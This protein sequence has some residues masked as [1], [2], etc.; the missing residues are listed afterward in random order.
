MTEFPAPPPEPLPEPLPALT[1]VSTWVP[2]VTGVVLKV[3]PTEVAALIGTLHVNDDDGLADFVVYRQPSPLEGPR[4]ADV[5]VVSD[6]S[7]LG[8]DQP[9]L[10]YALRGLLY[11][12]I[13][14]TGPTR[15]LHS[16]E[17]GG[18]VMNP[19]NALASWAIENVI[20]AHE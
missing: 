11:T 6:T 9:A 3:A 4:D 17:F 15:D 13:E 7:M 2:P 1:T 18:A 16:G 12:Q 20:V 19:A 10:C 8:A 14:V 5:I